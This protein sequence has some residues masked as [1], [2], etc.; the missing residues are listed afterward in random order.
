MLIIR[1]EGGVGVVS[2]R[3]LLLADCEPLAGVDTDEEPLLVEEVAELVD[4]PDR[5]GSRPES[6]KSTPMAATSS[7][8][9]R[10]ASRK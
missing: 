1:P 5:D 2:G 10:K 7:A 6:I 9:T 3:A 4:M 8:T